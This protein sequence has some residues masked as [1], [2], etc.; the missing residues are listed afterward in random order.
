MDAERASQA[1]QTHTQHGKKSRK[2]RA[3]ERANRASYR[4]SAQHRI[5][6]EDTCKRDRRIKCQ[7][8]DMKKPRNLKSL[9]TDE[10]GALLTC[11]ITT[12]LLP[13]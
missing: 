10:R 11:R 7:L 12:C 3:S 5:R 8:V 1:C 9:A 4:G 2:R 6:T 13:V